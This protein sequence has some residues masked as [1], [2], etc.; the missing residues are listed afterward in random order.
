M[1]ESKYELKKDNQ[2]CTAFPR[3]VRY[4]HFSVQEQSHISPISYL[5]SKDSSENFLQKKLLIS[6]D[7]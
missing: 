1:T 3:T 4:S 2:W 7:M 6:Y 5:E